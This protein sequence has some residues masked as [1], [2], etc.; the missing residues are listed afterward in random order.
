MRGQLRHEPAKRKLVAIGAETA[1]DSNGGW[2][3]HRMASLRLS[4]VHVRDV[5]FDERDR[6][7]GERVANGETR[8]AVRAR[9]HDGTGD[10]AS[11]TVNEFYELTLAI[12]LHELDAGTDL[13]AD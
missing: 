8:V 4:G 7:S 3:Q 1:N 10:A 12:A 11:Q 13:M 5:H 2:R 6:D 9:V